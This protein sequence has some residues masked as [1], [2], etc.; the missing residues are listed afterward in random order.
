MTK[1]KGKKKVL[2]ALGVP[3]VAIASGMKRIND[4]QMRGMGVNIPKKKL[5]TIHKENIKKL[6][7]MLK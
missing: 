7:K 3:P 4:A 6:K 2:F 1:K 5:S